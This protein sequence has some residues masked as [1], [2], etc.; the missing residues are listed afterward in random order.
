MT[1]VK[2]SVQEQIVECDS[3]TAATNSYGVA[4]TQYKDN[5]MYQAPVHANN[6]APWIKSNLFDLRIDK[7]QNLKSPFLY[8][9][10]DIISRTSITRQALVN[11][12]R[13]YCR[14]LIITSLRQPP[15]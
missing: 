4:G 10:M 15:G 7:S 9:Y 11:E 14:E 2:Q 6:P 8:H 3:F 12:P 13:S 1:S 5:I